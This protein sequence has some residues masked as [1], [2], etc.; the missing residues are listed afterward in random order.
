MINYLTMFF[1]I[2]FCLNTALPD[3]LLLIEDPPLQASVSPEITRSPVALTVKYHRVRVT[4]DNQVAVTSIDQVFKN[5]YDADL[6]GTYIFPLPEEAAISDF[7]MY[8]NGTRVSGEILDKEKARQVYE[9]IVRRM[10]DPGLLEYVGRNMFRARVYPIPKHGETRI[11]LRYE[12]TLEY[13]SGVYR[14][15]YPLDTERFSPGLLEEVTISAEVKSSVPIKSIYSPSHRVD[16]IKEQF[17]AS[18]SYEE[19][20]VRPDKDFVLYYTVSEKDVGLNLLCFKNPPDDG[21]DY[22]ETCREAVLK[23]III[24]TIQYGD[25]P[26]TMKYW[27]RIAK[28]SEGSYTAITQP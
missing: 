26:E 5:E 11:E 10:K 16:I 13:D 1:G 25:Y 20:N 14:Y 2:L 27:R 17:Q 4:I 9:D 18:L 12:Q 28:L 7:A 21:Y 8:I 24:N 6:E 3:G 22:K 15:V 19:D 23:D